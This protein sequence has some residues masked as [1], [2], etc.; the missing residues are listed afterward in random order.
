MA[1]LEPP[2]SA[3]LPEFARFF[4]STDKQLY[5][6]GKFVSAKSGKTFPVF[7]PATGGVLAN[8]AEGD[9]ADIDAAVVAA[10]RAFTTGSWPAMS[11][12]ERSRLLYKLADKMEERAEDLALLESLDNGKPLSV[13][14]VADIPLSIDNLRYMAG[15]ATKIAVQSI[16][17]GPGF[18]SYTRREPIGVVGQII[19]WN[20]PLLMFVWKVGPA[21]ATGCTIVMKPAEQTPL[22]AVLMAELIAEVG[23]PAGVFNCVP[24][25]GETAGARIAS[26]P[27]IDKVAFTGS[28]EVGR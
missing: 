13:A 19:P 20:F 28:T 8:V 15:W 4:V 11:P 27:D 17:M 6:D 1:L 21:L 16:N 23:F 25:N 24:G 22:S 26:H 2:T 10:R 7:N 14:R 3:P 9:V 18:H 12:S 5:I